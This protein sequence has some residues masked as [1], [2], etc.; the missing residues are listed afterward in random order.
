[1]EEEIDSSN[2][3]LDN[4]TNNKVTKNKDF[5]EKEKTNKR[6]SFLENDSKINEELSDLLEIKQKKTEDDEISIEI[7][8]VLPVKDDVIEE[9]AVETSPMKTNDNDNSRSDIQYQV[10]LEEE[11]EE[12]KEEE[13]EEEENEK[14]ESYKKNYSQLENSLVINKTMENFLSNGNTSN[15]FQSKI[16]DFSMIN[17]SQQRLSPIHINNRKYPIIDY[18]NDTSNKANGS[19]NNILTDRSLIIA[20]PSKKTFNKNSLLINNDEITEEK[21]GVLA[22]FFKQMQLSYFDEL[23]EYL[24]NEKNKLIL[25]NDFYKSNNQIKLFISNEDLNKIE[26][27]IVYLN[28]YTKTPMLEIDRFI[29]NELNSKLETSLANF[30]KINNDYNDPENRKKL[31]FLLQNFKVLKQD[32]YYFEKLID[33]FRVMKKNCDLESQK[34]WLNWRIQQFDGISLVLRDNFLIV[35]EQQNELTLFE[36]KLTAILQ[37]VEKL[38]ELGTFKNK[39][40]NKRESLIEDSFKNKNTFNKSIITKSSEQ[41]NEDIKKW[42]TKRIQLLQKYDIDIGEIHEITK[43]KQREIMAQIKSKKNNLKHKVKPLNDSASLVTKQNIKNDAALLKIL[44]INK[45]NGVKIEFK[46]SNNFKVSFAYIPKLLFKIKFDEPSQKIENITIDTLLNINDTDSDLVKI[47]NLNETDDI[48]KSFNCLNEVSEKLNYLY[49]VSRWFHDL[50]L[51]YTLLLNIQQIKTDNQQGI[52]KFDI[53]LNNNMG[54]IKAVLDWNKFKEL[55]INN[56]NLL[57]EIKDG[58]DPNKTDNDVGV[59]L[60]FYGD[61]FNWESFLPNYVTTLLGWTV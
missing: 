55:T 31:P 7:G 50:K 28:L 12:E 39:F 4:D 10:I 53:W 61:G 42:E 57:T 21:Y 25:N 46:S 24:S 3:S 38:I 29:I 33:I 41:I 56:T 5:E 37:E 8:E 52:L 36:K 17:K 15:L 51:K 32:S 23:P 9:N 22:A 11:E 60:Y 6:V 40:V 58:Q 54:K 1:M 14:I 48:I 34:I 43:E 59:F 45:L 49:K 26:Q 47:W 27:E 35:K 18:M 30:N 44:K 16:M 19:G 13:E 20:S 2:Y